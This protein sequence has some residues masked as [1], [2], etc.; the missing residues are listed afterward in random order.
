LL[1]H[2]EDLAA[3]Q[4]DLEQVMKGPPANRAFG[5]DGSPTPAAEGFARSKGLALSDLQV[6]EMDGGR[7]VTA[8]VRQAGRPAVDVLGQALPA[9]IAGLRFDKSMRWNSSNVAFSRPIRWFLA[10]YGTEET[11]Q[12][13]PFEYAG[14][15]SGDKTRGLRFRQPEEQTV[16][17]PLEYYEFLTSQGIVLDPK[18]REAVI[19]EQIERLAT[20]VGG[21]IPDDPDLLAEVTNLVE[22][23]TALR[24]T[25]DP[26]HLKL[27]LISV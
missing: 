6:R 18:R 4:T 26:G 16:R 9:L 1:I 19:S 25:F 15:A 21:V 14:L 20:E 11:C 2:V 12:V 27:G 5:P 7:Y 22:A 3:V 10:I 23:P 17:S 8:V 13:V 24:G